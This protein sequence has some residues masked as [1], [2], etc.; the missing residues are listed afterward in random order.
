MT[1][2]KVSLIIPA[3]N[4]EKYI[5][6]CLD[7][8]ERSAGDKFYEIIVV[9]NGSSDN[10]VGVA[11]QRAGV[12]VLVEK[13]KG[14]NNARQT[15][16]EAASGDFIACLDSDTHLPSGWL[17]RA[18]KFFETH[19]RAVSLS[20]PYRY[21]DATAYK[22]FILTLIWWL[23][24]PISYRLVGYMILG[25][26]FIAR[27]KELVSAGGFERQIQFYGDDTDLARRLSKF[28]KAVFKMNFYVYS[29]SRR[30][31]KEGLIKT[32]MLYGLNFLWEV[33]FARP[34]TRAYKDIR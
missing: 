31:A 4:E 10:T 32:N 5:G 21:F 16:L 1:D 19:P 26:N 24:A 23:S 7:T 20:G 27:R 29:S 33:L 6:E 12:K 17:S 13:R 30:F 25:G 3:Y 9:D 15:G 18:R 2:F 11:S 8:A 28:G 14:A 34:F 22:N